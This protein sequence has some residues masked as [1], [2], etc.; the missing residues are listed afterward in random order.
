M[1]SD[2]LQTVMI[3]LTDRAWLPPPPPQPLLFKNLQ[4]DISNVTLITEIWAFRH[5]GPWSEGVQYECR[6]LL[7]IFPR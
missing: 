5:T 3:S 6:C 7:P 1:L 2:D 4:C